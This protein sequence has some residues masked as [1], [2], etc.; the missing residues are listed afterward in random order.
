VPQTRAK[1]NCQCRTSGPQGIMRH[2]VDFGF[3]V[4]VMTQ[5]ISC[6]LLIAQICSET[7]AA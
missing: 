2:S 4:T 5:V 7:I 6:Q 1:D 3:P